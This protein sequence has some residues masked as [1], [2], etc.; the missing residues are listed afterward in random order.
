MGEPRPGQG[1]RRVLT[2]AVVASRTGRP[3]DPS[4][5][6]PF[7]ARGCLELPFPPDR[8]VTWTNGPGTIWFAGWQAPSR[9]GCQELRWHVDAEGLT[10]F[11]GRVWPRRDGW[12]GAASVATQ[13]ARYL[14][15]RPLVGNADELAGVYIVASMAS[16]GPCF[17]AA[18]PVGEGLLYWGHGP[19][20]VVF[21]TRA[22]VAAS[23]LAAATGTAPRRDALGTGWLAY[24]GVPMGPRTGFEQVS[25]VPDAAV[26]EID[27]RGP[28][29]L[30]RSPRPPWRLRADELAADPYAALEEIQAEMTTAI[31]MALRD[32]GTQGSLGLTGGKDSRLILAL[33]LAEDLASDLQFE[34][35][36]ADD[37]PDVVIA[38]QLA[39][40]FDLRH[41]TSPRFA[42]RWA[43]RQQLID[44]FREGELGQC[45]MRE[46]TFRIT[47]WATSGMTNAGEPHLGRLPP[48]DSVL[49]SGL[50]GESLRTNYPASIRFRSK[51]QASRFPDNLMPGSV[52][53]LNREA[54]ARYRAEMH[55][56]L[57]EDAT[58]EDSP[59]DVIDT[60][61]LRQRVRH[62]QGT[63]LEVDSENRVFP[64]Y[65]ITAMRLAFAIGAENRHAQWIHHHLMRRACE[66]L[67]HVPFATGG[68]PPGASAELVTARR[69][70][71]P[72]PPRPPQERAR[73][74]L[75]RRLADIRRTLGPPPAPTVRTVAREHRAKERRTDVEVMRRL[76]G[77]DPANPAFELI[78]ARA[79]SRALDRFDRLSEGQRLQLYGALT[80]V[81]WL[82]G[83]E[84]AL[85]LE[86][87]AA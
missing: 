50:F 80:A 8:Q 68:W 5:L 59:Q 60:F 16:E 62:W 84:V 21:S 13:L 33:L 49:L 86:L 22:A 53:I 18:D 45:P 57:F 67:L 81:I 82:G 17:L 4:A 37:L 66:P 44:A 12:S 72:V 6:D 1:C 73:D 77:H 85:P 3:L 75:H 7:E 31:R 24:V 42:E 19:E 41:V 61:Y 71:D 87:S 27:P 56:L 58:V 15:E 52:G 46:I 30:H 29:S 39:A 35:L 55:E 26:V 48:D 11:A 79:V 40:T 25:L 32:P 51:E 63:T 36:G 70:D 34:T 2:F 54:V 23:V 74:D 47:A 78:D 76:F 43:W 65:S 20:V 28:T 9:S 14:R 83:H 64:L 10:A 38:R 69:Y